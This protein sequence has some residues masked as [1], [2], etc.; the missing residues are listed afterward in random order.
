MAAPPSAPPPPPAVA[1][2]AARRASEQRA[3]VT[4]SDVAAAAEG[5]EARTVGGRTFRR[6]G[7]AWTDARWVDSLPVVRVRPFSEGYFRLLD[8]LPELREPFALGERVRVRG[9]AVA[10]EVSPDAPERLAAEA[11]ERVRRG[12]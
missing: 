4:L 5:G 11:V 8:L 10:V 12:W 9:R 3:A 1:F 6:V 7:D 2:D